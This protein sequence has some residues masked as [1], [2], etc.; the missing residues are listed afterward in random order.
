MDS[1]T[2]REIEHFARDILGCGCP[3]EV[4]DRIETDAWLGAFRGE[5]VARTIAIGGRLLIVFCSGSVDATTVHRILMRGRRVRD[6]HGLNRVRCVVP[7]GAWVGARDPAA[8][9]SS[10]DRLNVHCV[11]EA[12]W[13]DWITS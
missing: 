12:A 2:R 7:A 5:P 1:D 6:D 9:G 3:P 13:P 10:D 4:F 11:Q 8:I